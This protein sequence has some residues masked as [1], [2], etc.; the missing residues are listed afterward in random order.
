MQDGL[1]DN[2]V[3]GLVQDE[4]GFIWIS[5]PNGLNRFDGAEFRKPGSG[6]RVIDEVLKLS[7]SKD[8]LLLT[9]RKGIQSLN[10]SNEQLTSY[11][12]PGTEPG[13]IYINDAYDAL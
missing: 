12:I 6:N 13:S 2:T 3:T 8:Q 5:T 1:S 9:T 11:A 10:T 4:K 7:V